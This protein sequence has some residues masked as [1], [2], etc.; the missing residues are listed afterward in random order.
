MKRY[1]PY[2]AVVFVI[3]VCVGL[4]GGSAVMASPNAQATATRTPT[5]T[6]TPRPTSTPVPRVKMI[7]VPVSG[8]WATPLAAWADVKAR[9]GMRAPAGY[10]VQ[11]HMWAYQGNFG[12]LEIC[13]GDNA[14]WYTYGAENA[15]FSPVPVVGSRVNIVGITRVVC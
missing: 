5:L 2:V 10:A 9:T 13:D 12:T 14:H 6:K 8:N 3:V 15:P 11:I 7:Q 4:I 1:L